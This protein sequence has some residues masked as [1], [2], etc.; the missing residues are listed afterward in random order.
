MFVYQS[1]TPVHNF[2]LRFRYQR[3]TSRLCGL[4]KTKMSTVCYGFSP[5]NT[6]V[7]CVSD[8]SITTKWAIDIEKSVHTIIMTY[9]SQL[10]KMNVYYPLVSVFISVFFLNY[11]G[12]LTLYN[13]KHLVIQ[14]NVFIICCMWN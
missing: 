5:L 9:W 10:F 4:T 6:Y 13:V 14:L 1:K 12:N 8:S 3:Q 2:D 7:M 11:N